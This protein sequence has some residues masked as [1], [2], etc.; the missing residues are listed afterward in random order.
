MAV[1]VGGISPI[2]GFLIGWI[3][4]E[5][6]VKKAG[7]F[8]QTILKVQQHNQK[9]VPDLWEKGHFQKDCWDKGGKG[10]RAPKVL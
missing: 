3:L 6:W 5:D 9:D 2:S 4:D 10:G 7:L 1:N 8:W